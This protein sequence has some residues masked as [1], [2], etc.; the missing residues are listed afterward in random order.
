MEADEIIEQLGLKAHPEG[1][2]YLETVTGSSPDGE[3]GDISV[4]YFLLKQ[5]E[6][7][8]WHRIKDADDGTQARFYLFTSGRGM[9]RCRNIILAWI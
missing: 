4:I 2:W 9:A 6:T 5:G 7:A 1:G 3:R 8:H